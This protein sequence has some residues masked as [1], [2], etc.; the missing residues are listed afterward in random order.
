M[1]CMCC[2]YVSYNFAI[3]C[4]HQHRH[5]FVK[6]TVTSDI[7]TQSTEEVGGHLAFHNPRKR[8]PFSRCH[9]SAHFGTA[10]NHS[11]LPST[12]PSSGTMHYVQTMFSFELSLFLGRSNLCYSVYFFP[13]RFFHRAT[14]TPLV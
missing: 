9:L 4:M 13:M 2:V 12:L 10:F 5:A 1:C 14:H 6:S 11:P 3:V 8:N 7:C